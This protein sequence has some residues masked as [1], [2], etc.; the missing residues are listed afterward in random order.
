MTGTSPT[1][2]KL[3]DVFLTQLKSHVLRLESYPIEPSVVDTDVAPGDD[4]RH[5]APVHIRRACD[6]GSERLDSGT[7]QT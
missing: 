1:I 6:R 4:G 7:A 2:S 5:Q 3:S